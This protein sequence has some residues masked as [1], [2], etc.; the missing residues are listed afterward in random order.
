MLSAIEVPQ[1]CLACH[2][3]LRTLLET[4]DRRGF[5]YHFWGFATF[6]ATAMIETWF[7]ETKPHPFSTCGLP[8]LGIDQVYTLELQRRDRAEAVFG[9]SGRS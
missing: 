4:D 2:S 5:D 9:E 7:P 6:S 1:F 8:G 3:T